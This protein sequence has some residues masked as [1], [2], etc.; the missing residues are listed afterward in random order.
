MKTCPNC[1]AQLEDEDLFCMKCGARL[2][3]QEHTQE[4]PQEHTQE[5]TQTQY[6]MP[7]TAPI[8]NPYDHTAAFDPRDI[9]EN[10][11]IAMIIYLLGVPGLLIALLCQTSAYV[12][13]H[14]R[15]SLKITVLQLVTWIGASILF[16]IFAIFGAMGSAGSMSSYLY[17][18]GGGP[19]QIILR[20]G[21]LATLPLLWIVRIICFLHICAGKAVEPPIVRSMKFLR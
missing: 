9:S 20:M 16:I 11:V 8:V 19:L 3:A 6:G 1:H 5:Q 2:G 18:Y 10:K 14:V 13:F 7:G 15:Q 21:T 4:Q 17:G 12:S